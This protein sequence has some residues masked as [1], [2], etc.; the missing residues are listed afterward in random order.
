[1]VRN[2]VVIEKILHYFVTLFVAVNEPMFIFSANRT[3]D[4]QPKAS[5]PLMKYSLDAV[6]C[7]KV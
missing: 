2:T 5:M 3:D 4:S 1:M 6:A 7:V